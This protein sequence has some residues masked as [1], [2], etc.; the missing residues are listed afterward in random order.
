M[1]VSRRKFLEKTT[2]VAMGINATFLVAMLGGPL[3]Y[4]AYRN[5]FTK[6]EMQGEI[7]A[8]RGRVQQRHG[9]VANIAPEDVKT[10]IDS[11][12]FHAEDS[13]FVQMIVLRELERVLSVYP[14]LLLGKCAKS[15][16]IVGPEV[17]GRMAGIFSQDRSVIS[18]SLQGVLTTHSVFFSDET[19]SQ[20]TAH[21]EIAH[22]ITF[23]FFSE[24]AES[25]KWSE[26]NPELVYGYSGYQ[27]LPE[28]PEIVPGFARHYGTKTPAE[29][30]ATIAEML[31]K[32]GTFVQEVL[33]KQKNQI[34]P[35]SLWHGALEKKINLLKTYYLK[36]S[37][38]LLNDEFWLIMDR[39]RSA[40][41]G[42][43]QAKLWRTYWDE[44]KRTSGDS[45]PFKG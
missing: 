8:I 12:Y 6:E 17:Q 43:H 18:V 15:I 31:F 1:E 39:I 38:G 25:K 20:R 21:H 34:T 36:E 45:W 5:R 24:P 3:A 44:R 16:Q 4:E 28:E 22:A 32:G 40:G 23:N 35:G 13:V 33:K 19:L 37:E 41:D 10:L 9:V 29:D 7:E 26:L 42:E 2:K 27:S 14:P 30:M 11:V